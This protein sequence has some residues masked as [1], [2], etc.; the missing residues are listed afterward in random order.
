MILYDLL[1]KNTPPI[2]LVSVTSGIVYGKIPRLY[3]SSTIVEMMLYNKG[4]GKEKIF[5]CS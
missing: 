5:N 4:N 3:P 1:K 2:V